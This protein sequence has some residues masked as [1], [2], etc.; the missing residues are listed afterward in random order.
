M[1]RALTVIFRFG[2]ITMALVL[3]A[4]CVVAYHSVSL[5]S[6]NVGE[7]QYLA[8]TACGRIGFIVEHPWPDRPASIWYFRRPQSVVSSD[9]SAIIMRLEDY[10]P[11]LPA[12]YED[13]ITHTGRVNPR[14]G[15]LTLKFKPSW[16]VHWASPPEDTVTTI[17]IPCWP[18]LLLFA[19]LATWVTIL[20]VRYWRNQRRNRIGLCPTCSYD[21]HAHK[22]GD[23]CPECGTPISSSSPPQFPV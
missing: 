1:W 8:F 17:M 9:G 18:V 15:T 4:W 10:A 13:P 5:I 3:C 20:E 22:P 11:A 23:K 7:R 21:L 6:A 14:F 16:D 12:K 2:L 19:L